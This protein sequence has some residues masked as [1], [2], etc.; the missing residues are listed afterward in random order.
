[1]FVASSRLQTYAEWVQSKTATMSNAI[2]S[3]L[4]GIRAI[5]MVP[6][7]KSPISNA[8]HSG[9]PMAGRLFFTFLY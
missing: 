1:M 3:S 5:E 6:A 7:V 4:V 9:V 8:R 2:L